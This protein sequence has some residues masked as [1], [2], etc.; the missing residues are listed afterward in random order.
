MKS[1][2]GKLKND[3]QFEPFF[4]KYHL[5]NFCTPSI[6]LTPGVRCI[7]SSSHPDLFRQYEKLTT[8]SNIHSLTELQHNYCV[9]YVCVEQDVVTSGM[10]V[11]FACMKNMPTRI[12]ASVELIVSKKPGRG[13]ILLEMLRLGLRRRNTAF[14]VTQAASNQAAKKFWGKHAVANKEAKYL[15][16]MMYAID[17]RYKLCVDTTFAMMRV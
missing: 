7:T 5:T 3:G 6:K 10:S 9:H 13:S 4:H 12:C 17:A 15:S 16:L 1:S 14:I 8:K 11:L 2:L